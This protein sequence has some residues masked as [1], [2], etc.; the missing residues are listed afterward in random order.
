MCG[1]G[2]SR[3]V[4]GWRL[5]RDGGRAWRSA[6]PLRGLLLHQNMLCALNLDEPCT[7]YRPAER[8]LAPERQLAFVFRAERT[9]GGVR[10]PPAERLARHRARD[11]RWRRG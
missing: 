5:G 4:V 3:C 11:R 10:V 1:R 2:G 9:H 8:G 6:C 7:T